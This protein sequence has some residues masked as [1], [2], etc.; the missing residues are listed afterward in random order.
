MKN[1]IEPLSQEQKEAYEKINDWVKCPNS[2]IVLFN[3]EPP[4]KNGKHYALISDTEDKN[5]LRGRLVSLKDWVVEREKDG[6]FLYVPLQE[7][8]DLIVMDKNLTLELYSSGRARVLEWPK[9][10]LF[11]L[12]GEKQLNQIDI[13]QYPCENEAELNLVVTISC[14]A[15]DVHHIRAS[16]KWDTIKT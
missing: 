6:D 10:L 1:K 7:L 4:A 11:Q 14:Q 9:G 5:L 3:L 2:F 13:S 8:A 15:F 12:L 16:S